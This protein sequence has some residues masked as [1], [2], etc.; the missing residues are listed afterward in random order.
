[1]FLL[2]KTQ[3][4]SNGCFFLSQPIS[5]GDS[6]RPNLHPRQVLFFSKFGP[7]GSAEVILGM[8]HRSAYL[9]SLEW[10][11]DDSLTS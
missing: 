7:V 6:I 5:N 4:M 8:T 3:H 9:N 11:K 2:E 1:M 10:G